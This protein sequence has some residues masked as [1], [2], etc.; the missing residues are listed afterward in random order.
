M[1]LNDIFG[2][3]KNLL[4]FKV[5]FKSTCFSETEV[6]FHLSVKKVAI[7]KNPAFYKTNNFI[8]ESHTNTKQTSDHDIEILF[9]LFFSFSAFF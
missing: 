4:I 1:D 6:E 5:T 7:K 8:I 3:K 9:F 2:A